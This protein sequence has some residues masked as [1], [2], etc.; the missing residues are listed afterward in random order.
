M[1]VAPSGIIAAIQNNLLGV[2]GA[3]PNVKIMVLKVMK[4]PD[5][6]SGCIWNMRTIPD[7]FLQH[8]A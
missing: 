1:L 3:A 7:T 2:T 4:G 5:L 6:T 8:M